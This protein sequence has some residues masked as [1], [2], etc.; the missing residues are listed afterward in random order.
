MNKSTF[1]NE[2]SSY[3]DLIESALG[4]QNFE[5]VSVLDTARR[6]LLQDFVSNTTPDQDVHFFEQLEKCASE[7]ARTIN[8]MN[9]EMEQLKKATGSKL[10][11]LSGYRS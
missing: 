9:N 7:N 11:V 8:R 5:R 10:R 2:F 1:L 6:K 4:A 3:N